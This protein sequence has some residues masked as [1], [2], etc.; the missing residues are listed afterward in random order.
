MKCV[1]KYSEDIHRSCAK[2]IKKSLPQ[3]FCR[4]P[5]RS[6]NPAEI[7]KQFFKVVLI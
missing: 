4:N 3:L 5:V 7:L 2:I 6:S 1:F